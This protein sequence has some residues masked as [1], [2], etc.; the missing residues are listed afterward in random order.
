MLILERILEKTGYKVGAFSDPVEALEHSKIAP[1]AYDLLLT[2]IRMPKMSGFELAKQLKSINPS[3]RVI[4]LTAFEV[5]RQQIE[6]ELVPLIS[7]AG[8]RGG[9]KNEAA[10]I[11]PEPASLEKIIAAVKEVL[12]DYT[13]LT[14]P[15]DYEHIV[16]LYSGDGDNSSI[17]STYHDIIAEYINA[18]L[19]K[20]QPCVYT[21]IEKDAETAMA[22]LSQ[23][24]ANYEEN[25]R[26]GNLLLVDFKPYCASAM[27]GDLKPFEELMRVVE[28]KARNKKDKHARIVGRAAGWLYEN[29]YFHQCLALERWWHTKP[30]TG[31]LV[32]PYRMSLF[33]HKQFFEHKDALFERHDT[34]LRI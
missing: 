22:A 3:T 1:A 34:I 8:N 23:R 16:V 27:M 17:P 31:S 4:F 20:N 30:F 18:G 28:E 33:E 29:K 2:D 6:K 19:A 7:S 21:Y 32:C 10:L 24:I 12:S 14:S 5:T 9:A 15:S 11:I 26:N 13:S 25:L